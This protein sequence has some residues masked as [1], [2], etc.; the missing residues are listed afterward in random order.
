M[1]DV[2][3][4]VQQIAD[5]G[6]ILGGYSNSTNTGDKIEVGNGY[7]DYWVIKLDSTGSVIWQNTIGGNYDDYLFD[8]IQ[9]IDGGFLLGGFSA[10]NL[11]GDKTEGYLGGNDF[12]IIK[13]DSLG[14]IEWQN[15]IGGSYTDQFSM[16]QTLD[17]GYIL[18]GSS[19]SGISADKTEACIG[20]FD[21]WILK[22]DIT[23]NIEWQHTF[24]GNLDDELT[25]IQQTTDNGYILGGYSLSGLSGDKTEASIGGFDYWIVKL[26]SSG[27]IQWQQTIGGNLDDK[28][29]SIKQNM[30]GGYILCG[31]SYSDASG[32]KTEAS[33]G[34][35]GYA[36]Y[37]I[38]K[39]NVVGEIE[40]QHTIGGDMNDIAWD[41][42][43]CFDGGYIVGGYSFSGVSGDKTEENQ[44]NSDYW[45]VRLNEAGNIV[46]QKTIG[47]NSFDVLFSI[48]ITSDG[49]TIL[50]GYSNSQIS[51]DK[52]EGNIGAGT[53]YADYWV[54]KL[55]PEECIT[56]VEFYAD[57]DGDGFG[58]VAD[59]I[60]ACLPLLG[61][62]LNN[63]DCDDTD[64]TI[65][66][67]APELCNGMD[68]NCNGVV[69]EGLTLFSLYFDEDEDGFG[70]TLIDTTTCLTEI[71]GYVPD[72]TDCNDDDNT[73]H[74]P[75][76]FYADADGDSF[77]DADNT[78]YF[79]SLLPPAGFVADS[80]DCDETNPDIYPGAIEICNAFDDNCNSEIDE[81][82]PSNIFFEDSDGDG[83]GNVL[84][85]TITCLTFITGY[86]SDSTDCDDTNPDINPGAPEVQ[87]SI[88]DNCN[89]SIDE[90]FV[91]L[92]NIVQLDF[93]IYP[94]PNTGEFYLIFQNNCMNSLQV[95]IANLCGQTIYSQIF[96]STNNIFIRLS[97]PYSGIAT[98]TIKCDTKSIHKLV[99]IF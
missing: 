2:L 15:T 93:E 81:G 31:Y 24:G 61:Y 72:S 98:V 76:L 16:E 23:G 11:S 80:T 75:V 33:I 57:I 99:H 39:I 56:P 42:S 7:Y 3:Y 40:W 8:I 79:C 9:T 1:D 85:Y 4:S 6:Y 65:Y 46:W 41:I 13:L 48:E 19:K 14:N 20:G 18:G 37:W 60:S 45:I 49:G 30:D 63:T 77:G 36:D 73:I 66:P 50:G 29:R 86:V 55:F 51:G 44:G 87:N 10:S 43:Q 35:F 67:G 83:Y 28:L 47:G 94:N 27:S 34:P 22:I 91:D 12:W 62:V 84:V 95:S 53:S 59:S 38:V 58:D 82:L 68:D 52:T 32:D 90:G 71:F 26:D 70:N 78:V 5:G 97:E 88:D 21:Y 64:T 69:D 25:S 74:E 54:V 17:G 96:F 92:Q 89:D